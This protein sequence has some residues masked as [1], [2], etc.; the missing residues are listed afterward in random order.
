MGTWLIHTWN[1]THSKDCVHG[2]AEL[3]LIHIWNYS[4]THLTWLI[5]TWDMTHLCV[6]L[7]SFRG[8]CADS[9]R[10]M[11]HAYVTWLIHALDLP[12]SRM[13]HD[14]LRG[15]GL[16]APSSRNMTHSHVGHDSLACGTRFIRM[17]NMTHSH[18]GHDSPRWLRAGSNKTLGPSP[19]QTHCNKLQHTLQHTNTHCN[20]GSCRDIRSQSRAGGRYLCAAKPRSNPPS[21]SWHAASCGQ[22]TFSESQYFLL[23]VGL[24]CRFV[25]LFCGFVGL[26]CRFVGS[27]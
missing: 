24:F 10:D 25:G 6:K 18:V 12:H 13:M 3:W 16:C 7:D 8:L 19:A 4:S 5:H 22:G 20:T 11:T 17:W 26:F 23:C 9:S 1:M 27:R 2:V 15:L 14:S 21:R